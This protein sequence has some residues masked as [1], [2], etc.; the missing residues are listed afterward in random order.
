MTQSQRVTEWTSPRIRKWVRLGPT[1]MAKSS[2]FSRLT[3]RLTGKVKMLLSSSP[4]VC[5]MTVFTGSAQRGGQLRA[6]YASK[7]W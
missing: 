5:C 2:S 4:S 1:Q 7:R 3:S 6:K